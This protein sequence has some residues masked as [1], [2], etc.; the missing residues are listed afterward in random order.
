MC[1]EVARERDP[2]RYLLAVWR[3]L[4]DPTDTYEV[5]IVEMGFA[6]SRLG[7]RFARWEEVVDALRRDPRTAPALLA[8]RPCDPIDLSELAQKPAGTLGRIFAEHCRARGIN[9]NLA[10]IPPDSDADWVLHHIALTHDIWHV[11]TG[12]G[13]DLA[14]ETGIG[15]FYMGQLGAPAFFGYLV[16]LLSLS[17]ALRRRSFREFMDAVTSGYEMGKRAEPLLGVDWSTL[18]DVPLRD[19]RE[20]LGLTGGRVF[21]EGIRAAA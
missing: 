12:W 18:W 11:A 3:T 1:E 20:R 7:R 10:Y 4:R 17:T 21:G 8:R 16:G 19:V 13:N 14:G 15:G 6:R 5:A 2:L 9:P